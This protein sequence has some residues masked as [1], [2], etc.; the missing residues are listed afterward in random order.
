[1]VE[2]TGALPEE[3]HPLARTSGIEPWI[4]VTDRRRPVLDS[5]IGRAAVAI[6]RFSRAART[7]RAT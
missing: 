4:P 3:L 5:R 2:T 6:D 1:V 7:R